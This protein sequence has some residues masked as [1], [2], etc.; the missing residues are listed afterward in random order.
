MFFWIVFGIFE[1]LFFFAFVHRF[2]R[3]IGGDCSENFYYHLVSSYLSVV[4]VL[5]PPKQRRQ[6]KREGGEVPSCVVLDWF[7]FVLR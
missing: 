7:S 6:S 5:A 4:K 3:S 2:S 1:F